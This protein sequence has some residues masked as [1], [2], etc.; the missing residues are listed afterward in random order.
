MK[1]Q[2][3]I[4]L[5]AFLSNL[6]LAVRAQQPLTD[7]DLW[8]TLNPPA[9]QNSGEV[10]STTP[11]LTSNTRWMKIRDTYSKPVFNVSEGMF[12]VKCG[13]NITVWSVDGRCIFGPQWKVFESKAYDNPMQFDNGALLAMSATK[14]SAGREYYSILYQDGSV[15]NLS[16]D[17][18]PQTPFV[19]GLAIVKKMQGSRTLTTFYMDTQGRQVPSPA[20]LYGNYRS[21]M[22]SLSCGMRAFCT[23]DQKWGFM[24]AQNRVVK[25]AVWDKVRDFSEGYAWVF[26]GNGE[27]FNIS[28]TAQLIDKTGKVIR[29][30][31]G[32]ECT[33]DAA[34]TYGIGDVSNGIYYVYDNDNNKVSY[35]D[36]SGRKLATVRGGTTFYKGHAMLIL[37][38]A[39][40]I[41]V[42]VDTKFRPLAYYRTFDSNGGHCILDENIM[43]TKPFEPSGLYSI[44]TFS[45]VIDSKGSL[46]FKAMEN[47]FSNNRFGSFSQFSKD[48]YCI[49]SNIEIN[50]K[51]MLALVKGNGEIA[52]LFSKEDL[53]KSDWDVLPR[54]ISFEQKAMGLNGMSALEACNAK[55]LGPKKIM[56]ATYKVNVECIPKMVGTAKVEGKPVLHYGDKVSVKANANDGWKLSSV[57]VGEKEVGTEPFTVTDNLTAYAFFLPKDTL[58]ETP[59]NAYQG[60][61]SLDVLKD[62]QK[63]AVN[64]YALMSKNKDVATPYGDKTYGYM[65]LMLNPRVKITSKT[66]STYVFCQ[67]LRIMGV[68]NDAAKGKKYLVLN[69]GSI[70]YHDLRCTTGGLLQLYLNTVLK[71][72]GYTAPVAIP[73]RYRIEMLDVNDA[74]G[75]FTCGNLETFSLRKG[76][77]PGEDPSI[78]IT[79][80]GIMT[81]MSDV[82]FPADLVKGCVMKLA[83]KR[84]D[85]E[86]YPPME[87]YG[88]GSNVYTLIKEEMMDAYKNFTSDYDRLF[89]KE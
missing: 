10:V 5:I 9:T 72:E 83:K 60:K 73:R 37:K 67:P 40:T 77:V 57:M 36:L 88:D 54:D 35:Y 69:G 12:C 18:E 8:K 4:L 81:S 28:Y 46:M 14:N 49:A 86:W 6:S 48:G 75:E 78:R 31:E 44:N 62:N 79:T 65:V 82:G 2:L 47:A 76:W 15:R 1:H 70:A 63:V 87:W 26:K 55:P 50:G 41:V 51:Q 74:T 17:W 11:F 16:P 80:Q 34:Y 43:R 27:M 20:K 53:E 13:D 33:E 61:V 32:F 3:T 58:S 45:S 59:T 56:N 85:I 66:L 30:V 89:G 52:W 21:D 19:D 7:A 42:V 24:D 29:T 39:H 71:V 64:V 84:N 23:T 22:R 38:Q 25:P 68:Q